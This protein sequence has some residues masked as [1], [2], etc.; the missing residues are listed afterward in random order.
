MKYLIDFAAFVGLYI[1]VFYKKWKSAGKDVLFVNTLMYIYLVFVAYFTL[2]PFLASLP[3]IFDHPYV[4]MNLVPFIDVSK[5][6]GDFIRQIVL[7]IVMTVPFGFL[8]PITRRKKTDFTVTV[9]YCGMMS[10]GIEFIQPLISQFRFSDITDI[11]TNVT[12][13]IAG[14]SLY[15]LLRPAVSRLLNYIKDK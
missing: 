15:K 2:M 13:G 1:T 4:P 11:I 12:G 6:R 8:F 7:N 3:F 10:L 14:Y 9:F 5:A